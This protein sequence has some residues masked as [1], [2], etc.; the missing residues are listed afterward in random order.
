MT[1]TQMRAATLASAACGM[2]AM[3]AVLGWS[4]WTMAAMRAGWLR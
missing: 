1:D 2:A 3:Y 4:V